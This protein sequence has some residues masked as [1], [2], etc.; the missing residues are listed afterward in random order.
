MRISDWSSD[1][2]SSDLLEA[3]AGH[4]NGTFAEYD[5]VPIRS[6]NKSF[7]RRVL[8]GFFRASRVGFVTP[9]RDGMNLVAKEFVAAQP[10]GDPGVP[11]L[12]RFPGPAQGMDGDPLVNPSD[13][14]GVDARLQ[15][16][17]I[18]PTNHPPARG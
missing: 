11:V 17:P 14:Q 5:W 9:L 18:T 10:A 1:V 8:A 16:G 13:T 2:C 12:S 4:V 7:S 15:H 6:P 3:I